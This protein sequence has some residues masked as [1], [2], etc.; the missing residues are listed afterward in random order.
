MKPQLD[1]GFNIRCQHQGS[2]GLLML[3]PKKEKSWIYH[4]IAN[5]L[6][7]DLTTVADTALDTVVDT[8]VDTTVVDTVADTVVDTAVDTD[9]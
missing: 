8:A 1:M 6:F 3:T 2:L 9:A 4:S 5:L 7:M